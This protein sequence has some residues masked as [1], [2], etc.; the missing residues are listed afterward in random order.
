[1]L[2]VGVSGAITALGDTLFPAESLRHGFEQD[3]GAGSHFLLRM[4]VWHPVLALVTSLALAAFAQAQ[5]RRF[6]AA[7][8]RLPGLLLG[9][10]MLQLLAGAAN[11][12][13]LAPV[14]LQIVHLALADLVWVSLVV[15]AAAA[16]DA[17]TTGPGTMR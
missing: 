12:V 11:V 7:V 6:G 16:L 15:L 14:W 13:L 5:Q 9:C 10:T 8:G 3:F 17:D 2:V 1:V 4:R